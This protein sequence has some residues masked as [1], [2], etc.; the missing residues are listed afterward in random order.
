MPRYES[1]FV[2]SQPPAAVFNMIRGFLQAEGYEY[3]VYGDEQLF[4]KGVG[5]VA[6]PSFIAVT[7]PGN[8]VKIQALIKFAVLPGVYAGEM[9]LEGFT[10]IAVKQPL[11]ARVE[12]IERM[13]LSTGGVF[14]S[15]IVEQ[16]APPLK[17]AA[18]PAM[19]VAAVN[20]AAPVVPPKPYPQQYAQPLPPQG[21]QPLPPQ[22][23]QPQ[24]RQPVPM[25]G[26]Y[27]PQYGQQI[28]PQYQPQYQPQYPPQ[29]Q[30][31]YQ[32]APQP[33]AQPVPQTPQVPPTGPQPQPVPQSPDGTDGKN[34]TE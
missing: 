26:Q 15:R 32:S 12:Y 16:K 5:V 22:G 2:I 24:Y 18:A 28:P 33:Y 30:P 34:K 10:G 9:N 21:Q 23:Q 11:K 19:P 17:G 7:F 25:Q 31:P 20:R 14:I 6:A 27:P 3:T 4:K 13:I 8:T 29:Y 1:N